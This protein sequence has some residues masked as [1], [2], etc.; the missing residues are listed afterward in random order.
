MRSFGSCLFTGSI[1]DVGRDN[2]EEINTH[3]SLSHRLFPKTLFQFTFLSSFRLM[4]PL[5][6][7]AQVDRI[8]LGGGQLG[9]NIKVNIPPLRF[10]KP[11]DGFAA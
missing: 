2:K 3:A 4:P 7:V 9:L 5:L 11:E 1:A 10:T 6:Y 8:F